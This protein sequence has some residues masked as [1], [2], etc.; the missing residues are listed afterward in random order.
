MS[1]QETS[2]R[3]L[4]RL[5]D[6]ERLFRDSVMEFARREIAPL[7][8]QMDDE[9]KIPKSLV[10]RLFDLGVMGIEVPD[11]LGGAGATLFHAVLAV[12]AVSSV[13]AS[14]G[15]LIDVQN[16]LC[17]NALL[18]WASSDLQQR[19]SGGSR[20]VRSVRTRYRKPDPAVMRLR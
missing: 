13:D 5:S 9:A 20:A 1:P 12:E 16:T 14:V 10:D 7:V 11:A 17:V 19:I 8:R 2:A 3:P 4:T 6:D 15:V 18:K